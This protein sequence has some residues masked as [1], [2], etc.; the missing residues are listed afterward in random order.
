LLLFLDQHKW[1]INATPNLTGPVRLLAA[2]CLIMQV[3]K[4]DVHS[5][6]LFA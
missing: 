1:N 3:V 4:V 6:H 2:H 5:A